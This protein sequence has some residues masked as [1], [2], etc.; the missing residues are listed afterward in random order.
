MAVFCPGL[1]ACVGKIL[2]CSL[3]GVLGNMMT[4]LCALRSLNAGVHVYMQWNSLYVY[5]YLTKSVYQ[6]VSGY[7]LVLNRSFELFVYKLF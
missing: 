2:L 6:P 7:D 3:F 4:Q 1:S 5:M